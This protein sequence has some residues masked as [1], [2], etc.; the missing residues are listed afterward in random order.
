MAVIRPKA[1]IA[2]MLA[3]IAV[4]NAT[5][6]AAQQK[7]DPA[8]AAAVVLAPHRAIY[9]FT[10][11]AVRGTKSISGL[12]GRMVYEFTGSACEGWTQ[13]MRFVTQT[14]AASG[15]NTLTDQRSTSWED[16]TASKLRFASSQYRDQKLVE[17]TAGLASRVGGS[18]DIRV[19]LTSPDKKKSAIAAAAMF[20]IQHSVKL[21]EAAKRGRPSLIADFYDGADGGEK[22]Y[23]V[24]AQIGKPM[25]AGF[26]KTL[27][28]A[29]QADKLDNVP[30][31]PV[32][33]SYFE[34]G[35]ENKDGLPAYEMGF[36]F[37]ANGVSR[38][39]M[40]DNGEYTMRGELSEFSYIDPLPCKK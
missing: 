40:I 13:T 23:S 18:E 8:K 33:L 11:G 19:D 22:V 29:G 39:L 31:W 37:Y 6:A 27:P 14:T 24:S 35:N 7:L 12:T 10:L 2:F 25:A 5:A 38:R 34:P 26:N 20:P 36:V 30:S 32:L 1:V 9:D 21:L 16:D 3:G 28:R 4:G 15:A 17:Q